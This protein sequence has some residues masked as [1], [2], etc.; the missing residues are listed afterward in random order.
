MRRPARIVHVAG[1]A[2]WGGG[3]RY[4]ELLARHLDRERFTL[5]VIAPAPGALCGRLA[6]LG[7]SVHVVTLETLVSV[8]AVARLAGAFRRLGPDLVQSHGARSNVYARLAARLSG[9]RAVVS[10]VHN[11]LTDYPVSAARLAVYRAL[12]RVTLPLTTRVVC[13]ADALAP[14][15][16]GRAV[17][18][19]NGIDV[20]DF[21]PLAVAGTARALRRG[22]GLDEGPLL[23]FVGRLTPQKDPLAFV[24]VLA[25]VRHAHPA[26]GAVI[27]GDGPL[28][29]DVERAVRARG[30]GACCR[31]LGAR[32]DV[33]AL[34]ATLDVF[35]LTSVSE[36]LPF[37]ILEAMALERPVVATA[38]NGV[39]DVVEP[40]VT[41]VLV[42]RGDGGALARAVLDTLADRDRAR[43][44]GRA[45]RR[46]RVEANF[47]ASRMVRETEALYLDVLRGAPAT[48]DARV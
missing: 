2:D 12:D 43:A 15:Y 17:V 45:G 6:A 23:G 24:D 33:A 48:A 44:M 42:A 14:L 27:V 8:G 39:V 9:T 21:D 19:R 4:L 28:R 38:V 36:G 31:V 16:R 47:T 32:G 34:L 29:G 40:G 10:T 1:S 13:V 7:V 22:L 35:V 11:A 37:V 20:E 5:D 30:L 46:R 18:V 41:G 25:R 26:V 3:E